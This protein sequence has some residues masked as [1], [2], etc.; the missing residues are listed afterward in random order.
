ML[1]IW[2]GH[3]AGYNNVSICIDLHMCILFIETINFLSLAIHHILG[4]WLVSLHLMSSHWNFADR[5]P[6]RASLFWAWPLCPW[7]Q[8]SGH[9]RVRT[10]WMLHCRILTSIVHPL[11]LHSWQQ[12]GTFLNTLDAVFR[13]EAGSQSWK[14]HWDTYLIILMFKMSRSHKCSSFTTSNA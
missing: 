2:V 13:W 14:A 12:N 3:F 8:V 6:P 7:S 5:R 4:Y 11:L 10:W 1:D 9:T